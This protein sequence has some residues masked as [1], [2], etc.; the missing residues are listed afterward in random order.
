MIDAQHP[1]LC[2][3]AG[4]SA[5]DRAAR[6]VKHIDVAAGARRG[7]RGAFDLGAFGANARE[8]VTHTAATAHGFGGFAQG[9]V[10]A[11]KAFVVYTL[12]AVAHGLHEAVDQGGL[13]VGARCAHD[14]ASANR[15]G[16]EVGQKLLFHLGAAL[17]FFDRGQGAGHAAKQLVE[18]AFAALEV[19]FRQHIDADVL[20]GE[21]DTCL[22]NF[23]VFHGV[24]FVLN[25]FIVTRFC[26]PSD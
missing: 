9:F 22:S 25:A 18:G 21:I 4:T 11:R 16:L 19:L 5:L 17:G 1:H 3:T 10:N 6:L 23:F 26:R 8:V 15:A 24:L 14:A 7:G 20:R 13:N 2:A 12:N